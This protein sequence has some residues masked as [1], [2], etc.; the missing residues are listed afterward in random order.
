M[1]EQNQEQEQD[2]NGGPV[3]A[4]PQMV[5]DYVIENALDTIQHP[6]EQC[7]FCIECKSIQS[8][9]HMIRSPFFGGADSVPCQYCGGVTIITFNEVINDA[10]NSRMDQSRGLG[11]T[12]SVDGG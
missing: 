5:A 11:S 7:G 12:R 9:H 6:E 2:E 10:F 3:N 1:A 8:D 4:P